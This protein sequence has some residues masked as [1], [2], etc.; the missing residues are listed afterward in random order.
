M[1][2]ERTAGGHLPVRLGWGPPESDGRSPHEL[3]QDQQ[4][5]S[6]GRTSRAA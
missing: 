3:D 1:K 4:I 2:S 5:R 6:R